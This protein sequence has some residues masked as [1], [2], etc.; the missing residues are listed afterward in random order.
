[1]FQSALAAW[2]CGWAEQRPARP[3]AA[4]TRRSFSKHAFEI[5]SRADRLRCAAGRAGV[6]RAGRALRGPLTV[7]HAG[8]ALRII[9]GSLVPG[10][11]KL[12]F[13]GAWGQQGHP[14]GSAPVFIPI[15]SG[16]GQLRPPVHHGQIAILAAW[17]LPFLPRILRGMQN[18]IPIA[19]TMRPGAAPRCGMGTP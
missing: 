9:D 4:G 2:S 10:W 3:S 7:T 5:A 6:K 16:A 18:V 19:E 11:F 1:M 17:T 14:Y 15:L 8:P 13:K 12:T